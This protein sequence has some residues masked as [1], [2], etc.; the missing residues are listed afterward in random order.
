MKGPYLTR[1]S[2][3]LEE[4]VGLLDDRSLSSDNESDNGVAD[5]ETHLPLTKWMAYLL[6]P[7]GFL[8][9]LHWR[10]SMVRFVWFFLPSFLQGRQ[11]REQIRPAKMHPTAYLD[12]MRGLAALFVFFCHYTYQGFS[13]AFAWGFDGETTSS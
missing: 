13:I 7:I 6:S 12:G 11:M 8:R 3:S 5:L 1:Q 9:R 2:L 10:A 4:K